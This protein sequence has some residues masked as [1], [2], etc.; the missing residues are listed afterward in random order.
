[1]KKVVLALAALIL[2]AGCG[3]NDSP[4][5]TVAETCATGKTCAT[6]VAPEA[7][8]SY[9]TQFKYEVIGS[10]E[11]KDKLRFAW[12]GLA[13]RV[14]ISKGTDGTDVVAE[15]NLYLN[16][17]DNTFTGE[18]QENTQKLTADGFYETIDSK[19]KRDLIGKWS[20]Q[21]SQLLIDQ[22]GA[23]NPVKS[24]NWPGVQFKIDSDNLNPVLKGVSIVMIKTRS[25]ISKDNKT[26]DQF[27]SEAK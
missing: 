26:I 21:G 17:T 27:C 3:K 10:C 2:V 16:D 6:K 11:A 4:T 5:A 19:N 25:T 1:M 7:A 22:V 20:I 9:F 24:S 8:S 23:G 14:L 15:L 13:D 12:L 18:Y